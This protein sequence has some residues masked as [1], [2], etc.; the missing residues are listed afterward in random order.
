MDPDR[1]EW[2]PF[3][4]YSCGNTRTS[5]NC[6]EPVGDLVPAATQQQCDHLPLLQRARTNNRQGKI[7]YSLDWQWIS[8]FFIAILDL[9]D[10]GS[11]SSRC[12]AW[13]P[14]LLPRTRSYS[15]VAEIEPI[16][17]PTVASEN[18]LLSLLLVAVVDS[19]WEAR[20]DHHIQGKGLA[21]LIESMR[22][23][24]WIDDILLALFKYGK[25]QLVMN[26]YPGGLKP[27]RNH[28][29]FWM[30]NNLKYF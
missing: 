24:H 12:L 27:I 4:G 6:L 16:L 1:L 20:E 26:N 30:N 3:K 19:G 14:A 15:R 25:R 2:S 10:I 21:F 13:E 22:G 9:G 18:S 11:I 28:E 5:R 7:T 8:V 29:V 23:V 17:N